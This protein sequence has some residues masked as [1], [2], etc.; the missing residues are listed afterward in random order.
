[1]KFDK[2]EIKLLSKYIEFQMLDDE[3]ENLDFTKCAQS[4]IP[5]NQKCS[6]QHLNAIMGSDGY[7]QLVSRIQENQIYK[8]MHFLKT[9]PCLKHWSDE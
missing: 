5:D 3:P 4:K 1:M 2:N 6:Q 7:M 9:I 8:R